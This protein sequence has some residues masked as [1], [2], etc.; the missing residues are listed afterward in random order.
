MKNLTLSY[1]PMP[2]GADKSI[3]KPS[4][5]FKKYVYL[6][7]GAILLFILTYLFLFCGSLIIAIAFGAIGYYIMLAGIGFWGLLLG[8]SF[9]IAGLLLVYFVIKFLFKRSRTDYSGMIEITEGEQPELFRFITQVTTEAQAPSPKRIFVSSEVN[10]GVFYT[11]SFWSMFFP[12]KKNLNIGL[13]LVNSVNISEFKAIMAHEFGH[14]SQRSMKFG[15]YV[16]NLNK[17]IY[18]MLYDNEGYG[19]LLNQWA[20]IHNVFRVMAMLNIQIIR[21]IQFILRKVYGVLNKTYLGLSREMEFHADAVAAYVSGSNQVI[22]SLKRIDIGQSSYTTLMSYL[23]RQLH[24]GKRVDNIYPIQQEITRY[25][26]IIHKNGIDAAGLPIITE[27]MLAPEESEI[28]ITNQWASHP[29]TAD[30]ELHAKK[31]NLITPEFTETAWSL[32]HNAEQLQIR[33]TDQLYTSSNKKPATVLNFDAFKDDFYSNISSN[34]LNENYKGYYDS[35]IITQFDIE[36]AM[37]SAVNSPILNINDILTEENCNLPKGIA[38]KQKDVAL[39][40]QLSE[41]RTDIKTFDFR[42]AKYQRL[43][44]YK[45]QAVLN[46]EIGRADQKIKD[47]DREVFINYY[48]AAKSDAE[49]EILT[50]KYRELFALQIDAVK[51]YDLFNNIM[52]EFNKVYNPMPVE[53]IIRTL[54]NV[55]RH[56]KKIKPRITEILADAVTRPYFTDEQVKTLETYVTGNYIYYHEPTYDNQAIDKFNKAMDIYVSGIAK[57]NFEIKKD[58]LNFQFQLIN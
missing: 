38:D 42:G 39:L 34:S 24:D 33:L 14:F 41:V 49:R 36:E 27:G 28:I 58:L 56:E 21:G 30:R 45:V 13:G 6:S 8:I 40:D 47:L 51:D 3:I 43:D 44:A 17:V 22:T 55:S 57:R 11:S 48:R 29:T 37:L 15:S 53:G 20:R 31:I 12:V 26:A 50:V 52:H 16:Y 23:N 54:G 25:F 9:I 2:A 7:V 18:N 46:E 4:K 5:A 32:F 1:P 35:R 10:A 19:K